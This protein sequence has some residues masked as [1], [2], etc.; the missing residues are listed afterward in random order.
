MS[1]RA[2]LDTNIF[3]YNFDPDAP[4]AKRRIARTLIRD[5]LS[6]REAVISYQVVQEFLNVA[7]GKFAR[8]ITIPDLRQ[9]LDIMFRP[10]LGVWPSIELFETALELQF[11]NRLSWY[12]SLIIA[13]AAEAKCSKLYSEDLQDGAKIDGVRI[14]NPFR[15]N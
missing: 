2:F 13:A 11:R 10:L 14:E 4:P 6:G 15:S 9:L 5:A 8:Q 1:G 7:T 3:V 12:D